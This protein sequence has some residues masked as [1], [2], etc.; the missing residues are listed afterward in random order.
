MVSRFS[1]QYLPILV[2]WTASVAVVVMLNSSVFTEII[3]VTLTGLVSGY[4]VW[5]MQ[6]MVKT[7]RTL[8]L[9][10]QELIQEHDFAQQ[11][12]SSLEDGLFIVDNQNRFEYTN[13]AFAAMLGV[14]SEYLVGRVS[15]EFIH[16]EDR[17]LIATLPAEWNLNLNSHYEARW[18]SANNS[19]VRTQVNCTPRWRG[20]AMIGAISVVSPVKYQLVAQNLLRKERDFLTNI[21][22]TS[23]S[24]TVVLDPDGRILRFNGACERLTGYSISEVARRV[25]WDFL[26][27][28]SELEAVKSVFASLTAGDFPN[29]FENDWITRDGVKRR[30]AW[31]NTATLNEVGKVEYIIGTGIDITERR[32]AELALSINEDRHR[33]VLEALEEGVVLYD[34]NGTLL[35]SNP[36]AERLLGIHPETLFTADQQSNPRWKLVQLDGSPFPT[37]RLCNLTIGEPQTGTLLGIHRPDGS[38]IW[39][40]INAKP[41]IRPNETSPYATVM[42]FYDVTDR[43]HAQETLAYQASHD[44]LTG[45]LNRGQFEFELEQALTKATEHQSVLAVIFIDLDRFKAINDTFGH[46]AGDEVIQQ[47]AKRLRSSLRETDVIARFGGDEFVLMLPGI[48]SLENASMMA[49]KIL[50][51]LSQTM[52]FEDHQLFI[53]GSIGLAISPDDGSDVETLLRHADTAMYRAKDSGKN[54]VHVF[55]APTDD[56]WTERFKLETGLHYAL[57][58]GEFKIHY[59]PQFEL[60]SQQIVGFE[61]LLRW[62]HPELGE[63][64]P[65]RFIPLLETTGLIAAVGAWVLREACFHAVEMGIV[66]GRPIRMAVNVSELQFARSDFTY[67]VAEAVESSGLNPSLLE[68]ELTESV[69]L[70]DVEAIAPRMAKLRLLGVELAIDDFG[71][72]YSSLRLLQSLPFNTLKIDRSFVAKLDQ[73]KNKRVLVETIVGLAQKLNLR[74]VAE[75]VETPAE[76]EVMSEI[77]CDALQGFLISPAVP[78]EKALSFQ[79]FTSEVRA[80]EPSKTKLT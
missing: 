52:S 77:G 37:E 72:G 16:P 41:L 5:L 73:S 18:L 61:A 1:S 40:S 30:I 15:S 10:Q 33:S 36:S 32:E 59:Q 22:E 12:L 45:L 13:P 28:P 69:F 6:K 9:A 24:L 27:D 58:R 48:K 74:V 57:E 60:R 53:S 80:F 70:Q 66:R 7:N 67:R 56:G 46:R 34:L 78:F 63:I 76:L 64:T 17:A 55:N 75:G 54:T 35:T 42:S 50:N 71:M 43:K 19:T 62:T 39:I 79:P 4:L 68:L 21:I 47:V 65:D 51:S 29:T 3:L 23:G 49:H 26:L 8:H 11:L 2:V 44:A 38:L 31:T 20:G 25:F 14:A